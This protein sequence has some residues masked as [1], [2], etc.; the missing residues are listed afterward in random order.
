MWVTATMPYVV[1]SVLLVRGLMLPGAT[2]GILYFITPRIDRLSDPSVRQ[3][4]HLPNMSVELYLRLET[5]CE[6]SVQLR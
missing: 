3:S 2:E 6:K 4:T 1:L 5:Y